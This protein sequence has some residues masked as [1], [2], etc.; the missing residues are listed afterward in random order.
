[1]TRHEVREETFKVLFQKEFYSTDEMTEQMKN[2]LNEEDKAEDNR[3]EIEN[4]VNDILLNLPEIDSLINKVAEGW[5]TERMA[6][7]DLT[8]I[9]LAVYEI[10]YKKIPAGVAINEAVE[11]AKAYGSDRSG[12]FVNGILAK[13]V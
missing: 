3:E 1:M 13:V 4:T 2:F 12:S 11:I 7:V 8:L 9:R 10:R 5:K 6:K